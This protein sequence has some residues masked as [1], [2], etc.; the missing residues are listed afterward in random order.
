MHS[1][2]IV[3][4]IWD[5][6]D[7]DRKHLDVGGRLRTDGLA[8]RFEPEDLN[9]L[10]LALQVK[11]KHGGKVTVLSIGAARSVDVLKECL[12]RGVDD[13]ARL[14]SGL[15]GE[16]DTQVEGELC[17]AAVR[18]VGAFD[19][20]FTGVSASDGRGSL[21]GAH[22]AE[23]LGVELISWM[24]GLGELTATH[25]VGRR[26]IEMGYEHLEVKLPAALLVGVALLKDDPRS[27]RT[28]KAALK[29][30]HK[31]TEVAVWTAASLG[32]ADLASR[33]ATAVVGSELIAERVIESRSVDPADEAAMRAMITA[34]QKGN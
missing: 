21:L 23:K 5:T 9:A 16:L 10:E 19:L 18:K 31:K 8:T 25:V 32:L 22:V 27:P 30:K 12:Y 6:R 1:I 29:L 20:L 34:I 7:L 15:P 4:E 24:D 14:E 17:A 3:R 11:D 2:V 28:A 26:A 33:A 13:V